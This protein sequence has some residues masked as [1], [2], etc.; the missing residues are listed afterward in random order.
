MYIILLIFLHKDRNMELTIIKKLFLNRPFRPV[1]PNDNSPRQAHPHYNFPLLL[2]Q[3]LGHGLLIFKLPSNV[4]S[5]IADRMEV[6]RFVLID[7][8]LP[9]SLSGTDT[10]EGFFSIPKLKP[11][12]AISSQDEFA[13][14]VT[15]ISF[16][17][18][19]FI[20]DLNTLVR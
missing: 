6:G 14:K 1:I 15:V 19:S 16:R 20:L 17:F 3:F 8:L 4:P 2:V 10:E 11:H 18:F 12:G 7:G 5:F 9:K 13:K